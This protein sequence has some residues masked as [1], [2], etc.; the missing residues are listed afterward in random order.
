MRKE[1]EKP[2]AAFIFLQKNREIP[3][4]RRGYSNPSALFFTH[5]ER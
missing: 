2:F 4:M 3:I 5:K 1:V